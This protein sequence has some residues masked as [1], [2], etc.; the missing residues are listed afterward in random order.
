MQLGFSV[1]LTLAAAGQ[2]PSTLPIPSSFTPTNSHEASLTPWTAEISKL[3]LSG[4][5]EDVILSFVDGAGTFNLTAEQIITLSQAGVTRVVISA[6]I[7]HD[8][9]ILSGVKQVPASTVPGPTLS[10]TTITP[11]PSPLPPKQTWSDESQEQNAPSEDVPEQLFF[12]S[13]ERSSDAADSPEISPVRKPYP[14]KLTDP[15]IV[16]RG[17]G[18]APNTMFLR[19]LR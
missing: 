13:Y 6:M 9:D 19:G 5:D 7:Q 14:V 10:L 16:F 8:T 18:K 2:S 12:C 1:G 15:I 3:C 4:I 11:P 17:Y